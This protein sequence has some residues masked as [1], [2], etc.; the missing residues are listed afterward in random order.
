ILSFIYNSSFRTYLKRFFWYIVVPTS[1]YLITTVDIVNILRDLGLSSALRT[2][3]LASGSGRFFAWEIAILKIMESPF[4]GKGFGYNE[5]YFESLREFF[6]TSEHQGLIHNSFI[7]FVFNV[8]LFG[9]LAYLLFMYKVYQQVS[10]K[11]LII[12][13][14]I[15]FVLSA[16]FEDWMTASLNSFF[17]FFLLITILLQEY[18]TLKIEK[19]Y[20]L[21]I[22]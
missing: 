20:P 18:N 3:Q 21:P 12:P 9:F 6:I 13:V 8:G 4:F 15:P 5:Y 1:V 2:S 14:L 17:I 19:K 16:T 7:T 10:H 11:H 22:L